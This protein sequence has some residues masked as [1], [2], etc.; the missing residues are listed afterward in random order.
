MNQKSVHTRTR[1]VSDALN[2]LL[3]NPRKRAFRGINGL[4]EK[5]LPLTVLLWFR[6]QSNVVAD[7][8]PDF[9]MESVPQLNT[10]TQPLANSPH[11]M[12]RLIFVTSVAFY[13]EQNFSSI[14]FQCEVG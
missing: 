9:D 3:L 7:C 5:R 2:S 6:K 10:T 14:N 11:V 8:I 13:H 1:I 12:A 4:L